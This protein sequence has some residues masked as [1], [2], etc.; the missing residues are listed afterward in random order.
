MSN[1]TYSL[2]G[3]DRACEAASVCIDYREEIQG[4]TGSLRRGGAQGLFLVVGGCSIK[5]RGEERTALLRGELVK[6]I[7]QKEEQLEG[8]D[9]H[10]C[11]V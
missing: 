6:S 4:S 5:G 2:M 8:R 11:E 9:K 10:R 1:R 3:R 7:S